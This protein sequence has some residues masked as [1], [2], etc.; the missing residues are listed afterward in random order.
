[1]KK[2]GGA[3]ASVAVWLSSLLGGWDMPI[4]AMFLLMG[5]DIF[6]GII[7]SFFGKSGATESGKF[8][9]REL[10]LGL[11]RKLIMVLLIICAYT[12]DS[13]LNLNGVSRSAVIG[14]YCVS[15]ALSIVEN[16]AI[17]GVPFPK[18]VKN[19]LESKREECEKEQ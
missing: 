5:L 19:M 6:T 3:L 11:S 12:L 17:L 10:Y 8:S 7:C 15:E 16:A 4:K 14:F 1:M 2:A 18:A 13:M 9:S